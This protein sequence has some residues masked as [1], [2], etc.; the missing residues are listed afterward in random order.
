PLK[1][2]GRSLI[3]CHPRGDIHAGA[4]YA[5][6]WDA[7]MYPLGYQLQGQGLAIHNDLES[8][9]FGDGSG[10]SRASQQSATAVGLT[11]LSTGVRARPPLRVA[12]PS[13]VRH[14]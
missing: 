12:T 5:G 4:A 1:G 3:H 8:L 11:S 10:S 9:A 6:R 14:S 13:Q 7:C 2:Q